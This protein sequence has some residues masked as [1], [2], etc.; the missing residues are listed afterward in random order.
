MNRIHAITCI[1]W[2]NLYLTK[3]KLENILCT[4][5]NFVCSGMLTQ[6]SK[7]SVVAI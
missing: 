7:L 3:Y 2:Y 6:D 5:Y 4:K 1:S